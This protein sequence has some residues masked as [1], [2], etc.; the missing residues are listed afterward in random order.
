MFS[1]RM[2]GQDVGELLQVPAALTP[3]NAMRLDVPCFGFAAQPMLSLLHI[4]TYL[5]FYCCIRP[6]NSMQ[7]HN[8]P[9]FS[10]P[11]VTSTCF[12]V[13]DDRAQQ[14]HPFISQATNIAASAVKSTH[15]AFNVSNDG[16]I[17]LLRRIWASVMTEQPFPGH[18]HSDWEKE[19]GF[20]GK[21]PHTDLRR[22]GIYALEQ[23]A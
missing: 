6:Q 4:R 8:S 20:Q 22:M 18:D 16:H 7:R 9:V 1:C 12:Q 11:N 17:L 5:C 3:R 19:F 15:T 2:V 10:Q 21:Q 23:L 14:F 13:L